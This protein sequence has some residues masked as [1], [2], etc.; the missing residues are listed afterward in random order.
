MCFFRH[1]QR[2]FRFQDVL[3]VLF[4]EALSED[5]SAIS[6]ILGGEP[7]ELPQTFER[8]MRLFY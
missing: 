5:I 7:F 1:V 6:D 8:G 4:L 3:C 2:S